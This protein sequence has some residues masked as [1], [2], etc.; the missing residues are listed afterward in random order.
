MRALIKTIRVLARVWI[1]PKGGHVKTAVHP[2]HS[3]VR[4]ERQRRGLGR[5]LPGRSEDGG[6]GRGHEG[7]HCLD[8]RRWAQRDWHH[9]DRFIPLHAPRADGRERKAV[10]FPGAGE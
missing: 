6:M 7:G 4:K 3:S 5:C 8:P 10:R 9:Q 1:A 2:A